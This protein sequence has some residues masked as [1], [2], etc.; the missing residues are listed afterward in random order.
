MTVNGKEGMMELQASNI[1]INTGS[2]SV[3]PAI[4]GIEENPHVFYSNT[5]MDLDKL[6]EH[7]V[8]IG[9]GYIGLEFASMYVNFGSKVTVLQHGGTFLPKEDT[10]IAEEIR[11]NL[12]A[13]GCLLY[14]SS[15]KSF[16]QINPLQTAKL[17][18]QALAYADL[19][20]QEEVLDLYCGVGTIS[21]FLAGQAKAVTGIEIVPEAIADAKQMCIRDRFYGCGK[22]W[23]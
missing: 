20:G 14:T 6:P 1:F 3:I 17:Y 7:L 16:Y 21:L 19:S 2:S 13:Q 4:K 11:S 23:L 9:G 15:S 5:L 8:I 12:E 18:H 10:D 22:L